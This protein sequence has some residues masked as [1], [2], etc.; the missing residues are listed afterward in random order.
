MV[1]EIALLLH[2]YQPPTQ[3]SEITERIVDE[4]YWPL[5]RLLGEVPDIEVTLN[6]CA[7]LTEQLDKLGYRDLLDAISDLVRKGKLE[8]TG[9]AKYHPLLSKLPRREIVHQIRLNDKT[10]ERLLGAEVYQPQGFFPPEMAYSSHVARAVEEAGFRW[11]I[12]ED[13][14][15][16]EGKTRRCD[17]VYRVA[18]SNLGAFF[19]DK[20]LSL[21]IAFGDI[22]TVAGF[23]ARMQEEKEG[24][25]IIAMDGE[26]FG[27][28]HPDAL[29]LLKGI[30]ADTRY[31]WIS[32]SQVMERYGG[33]FEEV[34]VLP[35]TW[36][37]MEYSEERGRIFPRW[38]NPDNPLHVKQWQLFHLA[39]T[40]ISREEES[41]D[42]YLE[43]RAI[44]DKAVHSDHFFWAGGDPCWHPEMVSRGVE[45]LK[46]VV[47]KSPSA[48]PEEVTKAE[49]LVSEI[50]VLGEEIYG[51]EIIL[52]K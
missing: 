10:N 51:E 41:G 37:M 34:E 43:A 1:K 40:V 47:E 22:K 13:M 14:A 7:S 15:F 29:D 3:F 30:L 11:I 9:S 42:S 17:R 31:E 8:I 2:I 26:T 16:P 50:N 19:R 46:D 28:H 12:V 32:L 36:G 44:F 24:Y 39:L 38:D 18:G 23:A 21:Q 25:R 45:L 52:G 35:S 6:I 5:I 27:H 48:F 20:D 33:D 49:K 4:S